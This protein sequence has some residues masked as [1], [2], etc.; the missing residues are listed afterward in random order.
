M[1]IYTKWEGINGSVTTK[2][3][4]KWSQVGDLQWGIARKIE[5][6]SGG[7]IR[8]SSTPTISEVVIVKRLDHASGQIQEESFNGKP[9]PQVQFAFARTDT[10]P[11]AVFLR[12]NLRNCYISGYNLSTDGE[13]LPI[14]TISINFTGIE[15]DYAIPEPDGSVR[16]SYKN[17]YDLLA[18]KTL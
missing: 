17:G 16:Y 11:V 8:E 10:G 1:T 13:T 9:N 15:F 7:I 2:G 6:A 4:E 12:I 14:E 5:I 3:F 18:M